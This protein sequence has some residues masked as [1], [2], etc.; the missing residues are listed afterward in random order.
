MVK[1]RERFAGAKIG[2]FDTTARKAAKPWLEENHH[3][4]PE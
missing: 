1:F 2:Y 4:W 3:E